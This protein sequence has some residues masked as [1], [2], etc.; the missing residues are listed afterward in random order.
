MKFTESAL[1][2]VPYSQEYFSVPQKERGLYVWLSRQTGNCGSGTN[3]S[4]T[5][6]VSVTL[7]TKGLFGMVT[8]LST[9]NPHFMAIKTPQQSKIDMQL[10][11]SEIKPRDEIH[12]RPQNCNIRVH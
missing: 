2:K 1:N 10:L 5:V 11:C 8:S 12:Y 3:S 4:C 9:N 6:K 7:P